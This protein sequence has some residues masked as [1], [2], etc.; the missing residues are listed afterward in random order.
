MPPLLRPYPIIPIHSLLWFFAAFPEVALMR[1]YADRLG[2]ELPEL[3]RRPM[4]ALP[5]PNATANDMPIH[6]RPE[7]PQQFSTRKDP[8]RPTTWVN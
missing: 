6:I 3:A 2:M 8:P 5:Q 7:H 4:P 1:D